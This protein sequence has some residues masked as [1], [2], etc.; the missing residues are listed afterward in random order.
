MAIDLVKGSSGVILTVN[1][2]DAT[3]SG[4]DFSDVTSCQLELARGSLNALQTFTRNADGFAVVAGVLVIT[5]TLNAE[6]LEAKGT[7]YVTPI[8]QRAAGDLRGVQGALT[9]GV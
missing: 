3:G 7:L 4:Y 1:V 9:V 8:A 6:D 2:T 5:Y